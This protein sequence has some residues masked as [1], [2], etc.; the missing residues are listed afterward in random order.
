[1]TIIPRLQTVGAIKK[2]RRVC[3]N[4][5]LFPLLVVCV[6]LFIKFFFLFLV[7]GALTPEWYS[8]S[9]MVLYG[10]I[11]MLHKTMSRAHGP[12]ARASMACAPNGLLCAGCA[13]VMSSIRVS[14]S[15]FDS[16]GLTPFAD[17]T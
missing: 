7:R 9:A 12:L 10:L 17:K 14:F 3:H 15:F 11:F 5:P 1:M 16:Q 6:L 8:C 13:L 2:H 4:L